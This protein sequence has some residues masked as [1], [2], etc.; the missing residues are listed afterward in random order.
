[1]VYNNVSPGS[2][3]TGTSSVFSGYG[4]SYD[5]RIKEIEEYYVKTLLNDEDDEVE[6]RVGSEASSV[7]S[8]SPK[9]QHYK[10]LDCFKPPVQVAGGLVSRQAVGQVLEVDID[11]NLMPREDALPLTTENLQR[12]SIASGPS[13]TAPRIQVT[14]RAPED[15]RQQLNKEL[16]KTELCESFSTKGYCK[17]GNK[18]QFAHGLQELRIKPR[19]TNFRT[20]PCINWTKLGYC[21]Y[22]KRCCFKHGDDQDIKVYTQARKPKNLHANVKALQKM[23]W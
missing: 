21:P 4:D 22:G 17:Y 1:M 6:D 5:Y 3:S 7:A 19:A 20:K 12:L 15:S 18:C 13:R 23:T 11:A 9:Q 16:Y 2:I 8:S 10:P 14:T